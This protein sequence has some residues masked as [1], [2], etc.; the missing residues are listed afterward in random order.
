MDTDLT[1]SQVALFFLTPINSDRFDGIRRWLIDHDYQV[2]KLFDFTATAPGDFP[3]LQTNR[4]LDRRGVR[5]N[6]SRDRIDIFYDTNSRGVRFDEG[7]LVI[8]NEAVEAL[9]E[10]LYSN[11]SLV[12]RVGL[13][14]TFFVEMESDSVSHRLKGLVSDRVT[15]WSSDGF[16]EVFVRVNM[17]ST[18]GDGDNLVQVNRIVQVGEG[19]ATIDAQDYEGVILNLDV[20]NIS[21]ETDLGRENLLQMLREM[22]GIV[23]DQTALTYLN[24]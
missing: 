21:N 17:K 10:Y 5:I 24:S 7:T 20:N 11:E 14:N 6:L 16:R 15:S 13:I 19:R 3:L 9:L 4:T 22:V 2:T 12:K 18:I 8:I 1:L 23:D